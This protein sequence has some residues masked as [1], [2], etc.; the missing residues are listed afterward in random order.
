M[1]KLSSKL[2][3]SNREDIQEVEGEIYKKKL[4]LAILDLDL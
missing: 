3:M 1:K 4:V 2:H